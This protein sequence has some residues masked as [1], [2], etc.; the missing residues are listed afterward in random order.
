[1]IITKADLKRYLEMDKV[2]LG[3][4]EKRPRILTGHI[5]KYEISL[6]YHEY[7]ENKINKNIVD[8]FLRKY[9]SY[10]HYKRGLR[11]GFTIPINVFGGGLGIHH[12]GM[13]VVNGNAKVGEWCTVQQGVNIG[14]N[15]SAEEVPTLGDNIYIGPGAKLFG[16]IYIA[17]GIQIGANAVVNK[18]FYEE[19][20]TIAGIP[21]RKLNDNI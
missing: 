1:L 18:S 6:R 2:A 9:W 15:H 4:K 20:I 14:Q 3:M 16:K 10:M 5:W 11:L 17:S 13:V 21:A 8:R 7:F 19:G 12:Y